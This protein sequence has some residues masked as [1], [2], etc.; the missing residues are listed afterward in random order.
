MS[1]PSYPCQ[2][3]HHQER[4]AYVYCVTVLVSVCIMFAHLDCVHGSHVC[5]DLRVVCVAAG[6]QGAQVSPPHRSQAQTTA[7]YLVIMR[8]K[9]DIYASEFCILK[10]SSDKVNGC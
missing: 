7:G 2:E 8:Y 3:L 5:H 10:K 6:L 1:I 9:K 4:K